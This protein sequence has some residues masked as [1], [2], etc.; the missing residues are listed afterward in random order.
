MK[1]KLDRAALLRHLR[2]SPQKVVYFL[3]AVFFFGLAAAAALQIFFLWRQDATR[4]TIELEARRLVESVAAEVA[5]RQAGLK[6]LAL[7][8]SLGALTD[9][10]STTTATEL[11]PTL[12][13]KLAGAKTLNWIPAAD[14]QLA[15]PTLR[16]V[17][18][19]RA[20]LYRQALRQGQTSPA[21]LT[22]AGGQPMLLIAEPV[23]QEGEIRGVVLA[24]W[25]AEPLRQLINEVDPSGGM[26]GLYQRTSYI[27]AL[28][29]FTAQ[30]S[31][32]VEESLRQVPIGGT[33]LSIGYGVPELLP[34]PIGDQVPSLLILLLAGLLGGVAMVLRDHLQSAMDKVRDRFKKPDTYRTMAEQLALEEEQAAKKAA[35]R[36]GKTPARAAPSA[37]VAAS[38]PAPAPA[39]APAGPALRRPLVVPDRSIFRA[40]DIRG[41]VDTAI[42]PE[43][44]EQIGLAVGSEV[45]ARNLSD[46]IVARDGRL[47]GP[48]LVRGLIKGLRATGCDVIDVG[49]VPTPL[50]Y[51]ATYEIGSGSGVMLTGSHNPPEYNG[52]KIMVGGETLAG[53]KIQELYARIAENRFI[54]GAGALRQLDVVERYIDR[55]SG[56]VQLET[57]LHVI[58]DAGNGIPGAVAPRLFE[59]IG[60]QV[61]PLYCE[62]D[63]NFPNHHPDPSDPHNLTDLIMAVKQTKADI[64]L[65]F[66]GD[67]D[68]LGVV[69]QN[70]EIVYPDRQLM[71]FAQDVLSRNPG[72]TVI[73]D[74]KCTGA[75]AGIIRAAGGVPMMWKTGHSLIKAKMKETEAQL[76]GEMSGHFFFK[77][78]W[79]GFDDGMYAGCR[80]LEI[81]ASSGLSAD[82]LFAE[83]PKGVS[84]PELKVQ[85]TEGAHYVYIERFQQKAKFEGARISMIDGIRA[86]WDDGWGLVRASN[87]T[88]ILV[89][90]FDAKDSGAL[91][92]IQEVFRQQL[93][94][95]DPTLKL[96]F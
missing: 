29:V 47:S 58:L 75:L 48:D 62:V 80:L 60:C 77:E 42:T 74:V 91:Q 93:L 12:L 28:A 96:P 2:L 50:L 92:R 23:R 85:M 51:F 88:P 10:L 71:L 67:G 19:T 9:P 34:F 90:R 16:E 14:I 89:L 26:I 61:T 52:F 54:E 81:I 8:P 72:S 45:R 43:V 18:F 73:F 84:T 15:G 39:P 1:L 33:A 4:T 63:G 66:D 94:A 38:A 22:L 49:A 13:P 24:E 40:Y 56:D 7:A 53:E 17:G 68:R 6:E 76:A 37:E 83:L 5:T 11:L 65:A 20:E 87:T 70:G 78:R 27:E 46:V 95:V 21:Q 30:R 82:E 36:A 57:P 3:G 59:A 32:I 79:Y 25:P 86:D 55:V 64:G 69:L 44:A 31:A 41:I 35:A